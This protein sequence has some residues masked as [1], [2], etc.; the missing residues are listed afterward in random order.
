MEHINDRHLDLSVNASQFSIGES[1]LRS[2]L[3]DPNTISTPITREIPRADGIRYVR[4]IDVGKTIGTD[5]YSDGQPT[6]VMTVLSDR[7]GNLVTAFP[8]KLK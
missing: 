6:S 2:L 3:Q 4:E 5:K 8:G 1:D 7:Y